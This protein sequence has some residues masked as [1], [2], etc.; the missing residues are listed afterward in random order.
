MHYEVIGDTIFGSVQKKLQSQKVGL[1]RIHFVL[2]EVHEPSE[3]HRMHP[4][5]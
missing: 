5:T 3:R 1:V 4:A 2:Q